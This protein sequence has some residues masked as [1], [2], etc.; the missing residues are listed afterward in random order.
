M[1]TAEE[2]IKQRLDD[3][4]NWYDIKSQ[5]NQKRYKRLR[6][7]TTILA[8][9]IPVFT[10]VLNDSNQSYIK[11]LIGVIGASIALA[12]GIQQLYKF[13]EHWLEYRTTSETLKHQKYLFIT[14][15]APYDGINAFKDF[16][17]TIEA[18]LVNENSKWA[19]FIQSEK[20]SDTGSES[21]KEI[22]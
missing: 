12:E 16:V 7:V 3:Q 21:T 17:I 20:K 18:I 19:Q 2:Y 13:S 11:I 15:C 5:I 4:I 22:A 6:I 8:V 1:L 10:A 9:S 14:Q